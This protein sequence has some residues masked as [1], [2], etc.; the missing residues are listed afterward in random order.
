M[1]DRRLI[2]HGSRLLPPHIKRSE[3]RGLEDTIIYKSFGTLD[4]FAI[5]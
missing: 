5:H 3:P 1:S 2:E 4:F